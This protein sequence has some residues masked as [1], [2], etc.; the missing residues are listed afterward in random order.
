MGSSPLPLH[1]RKEK[2]RFPKS[3]TISSILK[4][5]RRLIASCLVFFIIL[6]TF[7]STTKDGRQSTTN[8][9]DYNI[10]PLVWAPSISERIGK[11]AYPKSYFSEDSD[12][13]P[14]SAV[15]LRVTDD[16]ESIV[17]TVKNLIKYPFISDI[18][19]HNTIKHRPLKV[20]VK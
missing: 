17:Y 1:N 14:V 19:I 6:Y 7:R 12:V 5:P 2:E 4:S 18:Y 11:S 8:V 13:Y 20:E 15:I 16:D 3:L 9:V 10:N